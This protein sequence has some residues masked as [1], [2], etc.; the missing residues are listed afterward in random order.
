MDKPIQ[1]LLNHIPPHIRA[2]WARTGRGVAR[3]SSRILHT[4]AALAGEVLLRG[5]QVLPGS[6][7]SKG[8]G[9]VGAATGAVAGLTIFVVQ[10]AAGL[11]GLGAGAS[12]VLTLKIIGGGAAGGFLMGLP[13]EAVAYLARRLGAALNRDMTPREMAEALSEALAKASPEQRLEA[14][15]ALKNSG[16]PLTIVPDEPV[17]E[18]AKPT[19]VR[20]QEMVFVPV[21]RPI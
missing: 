16:I 9:V 12:V 3:L 18:P 20:G 13:G 15:E 5:V 14:I 6:D 8:L 1:D 19:A 4:G 17:A 10:A 2:D 11:F 21:N 7:T